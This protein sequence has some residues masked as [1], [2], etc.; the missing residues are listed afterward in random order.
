LQVGDDYVMVSSLREESPYP[1]F[2]PMEA[3]NASTG[4]VYVGTPDVEAAY[5]RAKREGAVIGRDIYDTDYG[6]RSF[7]ARDPE[8]YEWSF[9]TYRP[10]PDGGDPYALQGS[11]AYAGWSYDDAL[12]AIA[13]LERA[14]GFERLTV[15]ADGDLVMHAELRFG[16]SVFMLGSAST[17]DPPAPTP[18]SMNGRFTHVLCGYAADPDAHCE[19]ARSAGAAILSEPEDKPYGGGCRVYVARD[20]E[21]YVW[22]FGTYRPGS[23]PL[24]GAA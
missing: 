24:P 7:S 1:F 3:G 9:G 5:A 11:H 19:R 16:S 8:G 13:W 18:R 12:G 21:G 10:R 2:V 23:E 17:H 20:P 4:S 14:F 6:S 22:S 15:H